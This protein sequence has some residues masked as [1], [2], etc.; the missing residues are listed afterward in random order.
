[1]EKNL[2]MM[3][4]R[5]SN[6]DSSAGWDRTPAFLMVVMELVQD[7][8]VMVLVLVLTSVVCGLK[9]VALI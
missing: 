7:E 4:S 2:T 3:P 8:A 5:I 1:M 9:L 6:V